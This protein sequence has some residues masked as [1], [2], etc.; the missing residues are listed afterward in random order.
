MAWRRPGRGRR[1]RRVRHGLGRAA[2]PSPCGRGSASGSGRRW[3]D[4]ATASSRTCIRWSTCAVIGSFAG[5]SGSSSGS[6]PVGPDVELAGAL[7]VDVKRPVDQGR[8]VADARAA[9]GRT[10]VTVRDLERL[11]DGVDQRQRPVRQVEPVASLDRRGS[12]IGEVRRCLLDRPVPHAH[13]LEIG[14]VEVRRDQHLACL[15]LGEARRS[16]PALAGSQRGAAGCL[17]LRQSGEAQPQAARGPATAP[18][19]GEPV[20]VVLDV[21]DVGHARQVAEQDAARERVRQVADGERG[22]LLEPV[23]PVEGRVLL[24]LTPAI[25][26]RSFEPAFEPVRQRARLAARRAR[27]PPASLGMAWPASKWPCRSASSCDAFGGARC[28][29]VACARIEGSG[30]ERRAA[31][32]QRARATRPPWE[33]P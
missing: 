30:V 23:R 5:S 4:P 9:R 27:R 17:A 20:D 1:R 3:R 11:L 2:C 29:S 26:S 28:R 19:N 10:S 25:S 6:R 22:V 8:G 14:L 21:V 15:A 31:H 33:P 18:S 16:A 7:G 12:K 13:L 24:R 32:G